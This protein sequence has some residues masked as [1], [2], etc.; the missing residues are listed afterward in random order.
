MT[1]KEGWAITTSWSLRTG[2]QGWYPFASLHRANVC[3]SVALCCS[4]VMS[5]TWK[6]NVYVQQI[7]DYRLQNGPKRGAITYFYS[8]KNGM[9]HS[10]DEQRSVFSLK[11]GALI[12][13]WA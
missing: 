11:Y 10:I 4:S 5:C 7:T 1:K 3:A 12:C 8:S 13:T 2:I 6:A 9:Q